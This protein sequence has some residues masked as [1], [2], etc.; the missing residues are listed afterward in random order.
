VVDQLSTST[1]QVV[2][3]IQVVLDSLTAVLIGNITRA[4]DRRS[5]LIAGFLYAFYPFA[6]FWVTPSVP[7]V[8]TT[9]LFAAALWQSVK[10]PENFG[11]VVWVGVLFGLAALTREY[12]WVVL[13]GPVFGW[14]QG[15]RELRVY[16][17]KLT[18]MAVVMAMVYSPWPLRNYLLH[19]EWVFF[20]AG[21]SGYR[22][23]AEDMRES[24]AWM[25][26]WTDNPNE[27]LAKLTS[28]RTID[29]PAWVFRDDQHR[30]EA[31]RLFA[32]GYACGSG[33]R[34]WGG[35]QEVERP[36][37]EEVASGFRALKDELQSRE[38][39]RVWT[40][41][42]AK[43]IWKT[44]F[45]SELVEGP[46]SLWKQLAIRGLFGWRSLLL[47]LGIFGVWTVLRARTTRAVL[48]PAFTL[49]V[50]M[51]FLIRGLQ[52][53][54]LLQADALMLVFSAVALSWLWHWKKGKNEPNVDREHQ[55][56]VP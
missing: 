47:I 42:P 5:G 9:F 6:W 40:V 16:L 19:D 18:L 51:I 7:D 34:L 26:L 52:I 21:S 28:G 31:E 53:R 3:A 12:L 49:Y 2:A 54:Y 15:F 27:P 41:V 29:V 33:I 11:R 17:A 50:A 8:L 48:I 45:K 39:V 20:R 4:V 22:Q 23:Y 36:C 32:R 13:A 37:T 24:V 30:A 25:N 55:C 46:Q 10:I 38:T 44:L 35:Q 1:Y 14:F 43:N 56:S